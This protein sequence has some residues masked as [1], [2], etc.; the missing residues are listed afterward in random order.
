MI[1][2]NI[3]CDKSYWEHIPLI[4]C[5]ENGFQLLGSS[6]SKSITPASPY[7]KVGQTQIEGHAT[8][9]VISNPQNCQN[10][11]KKSLRNYHA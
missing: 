11:K 9:Y 7:K 5:V 2:V 6:S 1:K 4:E 3:L 8:K 10:K